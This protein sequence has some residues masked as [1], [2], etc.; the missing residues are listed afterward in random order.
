[1]SR[2]PEAAVKSS[3]KTLLADPQYAD[4]I[5][6]NWPVPMGYGT[7]MLDCI[8]SYKGRSFAIETKREGEVLTP[9]QEFTKSEMER[10]GTK[11]F[12]IGTEI[13]A[14]EPEPYSGM[15]ELR[16]WLDAQ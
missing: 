10:G 11:V 14:P 12:V 8:G 1:M 5:W 4:N 16:E 9:R 15:E 2:T 3:V 6:T 13:V 7:P